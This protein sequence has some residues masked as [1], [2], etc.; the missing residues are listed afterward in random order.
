[1][2]MG[3]KNLNNE[4]WGLGIFLVFIGVFF[5]ALIL[6]TVI[7]NKNGMDAESRPEYP[8]NEELINYKQYEIIV[9]EEGIKYQEQNYP[10]IADGDS[11]YINI[12]KLDLDSEIIRK[13]TGYIKL[14]KNNNI[15]IYEPYLKCGSYKTDGYINSLDN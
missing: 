1:M 5:I 13:C 7:A 3:M 9:K 11:F 2:V 8:K 12:K 15:Y 14:G 4:G 6:I 10:R